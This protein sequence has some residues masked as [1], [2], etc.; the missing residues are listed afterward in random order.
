MRNINIII[1]AFIIF[2]VIIN[3]TSEGNRL[4]EYYEDVKLFQISGLVDTVFVDIE[5]H[6]SKKV[7]LSLYDQ[8]K[9]FYL[10]LDKS[11]L[12]SYLS[13][14]DSLVKEAGTHDVIVFRGKTKRVFSL[15]YG[16]NSR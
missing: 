4:C 11:S 2:I 9:T 1:L 3:L 5:N 16:C 15:D 14:N 7:I 12:F 10:D 6:G 8:R 13:K